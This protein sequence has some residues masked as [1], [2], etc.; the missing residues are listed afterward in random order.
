MGPQVPKDGQTKHL[1]SDMVGL[2]WCN[3]KDTQELVDTGK[4]SGTRVLVGL[5]GDGLRLS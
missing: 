3:A 1:F 4:G 2:C 5:Q